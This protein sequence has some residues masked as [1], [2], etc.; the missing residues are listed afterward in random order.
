MRYPFKRNTSAIGIFLPESDTII[1]GS[2]KDLKKYSQK[3]QYAVFATWQDCLKDYKLWQDECF[4]L[5]E[6]YLA[7][8]GSNYAEDGDYVKKINSIKK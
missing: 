5:K 7:F 4:K 6:K 2:A 3:N 1:M 8:L